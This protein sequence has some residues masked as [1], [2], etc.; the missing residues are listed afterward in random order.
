MMNEI[1][2]ASIHYTVNSVSEIHS[3]TL[4]TF[5]V[6]KNNKK[7]LCKYGSLDTSFLSYGSFDK[8]NA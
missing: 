1:A 3:T 2:V 8:E 5:S 4:G 7:Y 6:H